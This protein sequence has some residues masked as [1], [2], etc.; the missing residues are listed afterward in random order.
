MERVLERVRAE[1]PA[2]AKESQPIL[3]NT[4]PAFIRMVGEA[5]S[6]NHPRSHAPEGST[7]AEEHGGERVRITDFNPGD[8]VREYQILR[9]VILEALTEDGPISDTE[10]SIVLKSLDTSL[11]QACTAYYA[12]HSAIREQ[13]T[14]GLTHDL[15]GPLTAVRASAGMIL[16]RGPDE[17]T[18]KWAA[19]IVQN[20]DR[21]DTMIRDLLDTS[22]L[23]AGERLALDLAECELV[24]IVRDAVS[25][26]ET[27]HGERFVVVAHDEPLTGVWSAEALRRAIENLCTNAV[28]YGA[29]DRPITVSVKSLSGRAIIDVHN[30]GSYIPAEELGN[31]FQAFQRTVS[32]KQ[33]GKRGWGIGLALVRGVAEAHGGS[34]GVDS[35][36]EKG[37]SF[38]IDIPLDARPFQQKPTTPGSS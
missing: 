20:I 36:P 24:A 12:V 26:L 35:L 34:I 33:S 3:I 37:T 28:K 2:A 21:A 16:R 38:S 1:I 29:A 18:A 31:L 7:I 17:E 22:R 14:V 6:P 10:R 25:Q 4:L 11:R 8:L 15:R 5:L 13:L 32:A 27:M 19:R 9:D 30:H 23:R